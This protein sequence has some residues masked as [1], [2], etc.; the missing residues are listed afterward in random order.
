VVRATQDFYLRA[1]AAAMQGMPISTTMTNWQISRIVRCGPS[2]F[3]LK[4]KREWITFPQ[5]RCRHQPNAV[6]L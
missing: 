1:M 4:F 5:T 6:E 3:P 2:D